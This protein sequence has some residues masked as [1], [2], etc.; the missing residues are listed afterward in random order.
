MTL[1]SALASTC[2][3]VG[4]YTFDV[5]STE[6]FEDFWDKKCEDDWQLAFKLLVS[7][8]NYVH[9]CYY[10]VWPLGTTLFMLTLCEVAWIVYWNHPYRTLGKWNRIE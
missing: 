2:V 7:G 1:V 8:Y 4:I 6:T 5:H 3:L 10:N 9:L